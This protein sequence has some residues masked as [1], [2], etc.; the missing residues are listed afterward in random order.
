MSRKAKNV[1]LGRRDGTT[2]DLDF[3]SVSTS[4]GGGGGGDGVSSR[5]LSSGKLCVQLNGVGRGAKCLI[6]PAA[7]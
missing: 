5:Q 7:I 6:N 2:A 1:A 4:R 3:C